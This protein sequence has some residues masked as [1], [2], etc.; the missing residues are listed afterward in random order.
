M[1]RSLGI[2][3]MLTG[4]ALGL[5]G[6]VM[7]GRGLERPAPVGQAELP[8]SLPAFSLGRQ[9]GVFGNRELEGHWT[10]MTLG[11]TQCPDVCPTTLSLLKSLR[12]QWP[13]DGA[14]MP[15]VVMISVDPARD[16][17]EMLGR[18]VAAFD[19]SFQGITGEESQLRELTR[20]LGGYYRRHDAQDP[21]HYS[22][23]HST[24]LYLID[25]AGRLRGRFVQPLAPAELAREIRS[26]VGA[27]PSD[28]I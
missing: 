18:Y 9:G 14:E 25:P 21:R 3:L 1:K 13:R 7:L 16:G 26:L 6:A 5:A 4:L 28:S 20:G 8:G 19:P 11:Y 12:E 15:Q 23:D 10:L 17:L 2:W 24:D 22:V 27:G